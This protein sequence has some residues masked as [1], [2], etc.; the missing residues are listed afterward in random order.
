MAM[1]DDMF[2]KLLIVDTAVFNGD[3]IGCYKLSA[4]KAHAPW[5]WEYVN[6]FPEPL[7]T[8]HMDCRGPQGMKP[9]NEWPSL[10]PGSG[11]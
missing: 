11:A 7:A 5:P 9:R 1:P 8:S 2:R 6:G 4:G 10:L 3:S